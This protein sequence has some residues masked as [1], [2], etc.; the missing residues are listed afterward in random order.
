M[1]GLL[2]AMTKSNR[3]IQMGLQNQGL[4]LSLSRQLS[5]QTETPQQDNSVDTFLQ[6]PSTGLVY[7][8]IYGIG[9]HTR[10]SDIISMLGASNL[11]LDDVRFEYNPNYAPVAAM[12]QFPTRNAYDAS[13]RAVVRTSRLFRMERAD[14]QQWDTLPHYDGKTILLQGIPRNALADD[15]E[16]FLS[17]CQYD[18]SSIQIFARQQRGFDRP[19]ARVAL[20]QFPSQA[21]AAHAFITK[22]RGFVL[23]NQIA[24]RLLQ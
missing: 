18:G 11:S 21:L 8:R 10:K 17:G 9:R 20:V 14:R 23:N 12:I 24:V 1:M 13:L 22:N 6:N 19:P 7:G 2:R 3:P 5:T 16:R 15:V 4:A